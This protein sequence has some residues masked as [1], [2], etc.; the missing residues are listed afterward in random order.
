LSNFP[1]AIF[2]VHPT[3]RPSGPQLSA[4]AVVVMT[5]I[6][7]S[8]C[9]NSLMGAADSKRVAQ[10]L[11]CR[12]QLPDMALEALGTAT[13][14]CRPASPPPSRRRE[15]P[16]KWPLPLQTATASAIESHSP[17]SHQPICHY[18]AVTR[19]FSLVTSSRQTGVLGSVPEQ[20]RL[21][22]CAATPPAMQRLSLAVS[23][24]VELH[25]GE[26]GRKQASGQA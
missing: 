15:V 26:A 4:R 10:G 14:A 24:I 11:C 9:V 21:V 13:R 17:R 8:K 16:S 25:P 3:I 23:S 18:G 7:R 22:H 1:L 12:W 6:V 2:Q 5:C 20:P 19:A